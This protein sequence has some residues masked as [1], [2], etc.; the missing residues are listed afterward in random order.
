MEAL[1]GWCEK[2]GRDP[3]EIEWGVG[4]E[5]NDIERFLAHDADAYVGM[6]FRQFTLGF[7]GPTWSVEHGAGFL[8]WRDNLNRTRDA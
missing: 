2:L 6:G 3:A 1:R 4:V 5:P 7:N 8:A